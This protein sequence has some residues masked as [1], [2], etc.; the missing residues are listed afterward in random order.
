M[1]RNCF[2][3]SKIFLRT[4]ARDKKRTDVARFGPSPS[5]A[6]PFKLLNTEFL[7]EL[8]SSLSVLGL[9]NVKGKNRQ[10]LLSEII[11]S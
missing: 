5:D 8:I 1:L 10:E 4:T 11:S 6:L 7:S 2:G 3:N 9:F